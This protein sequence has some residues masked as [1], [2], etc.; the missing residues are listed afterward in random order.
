MNGRKQQIKKLRKKGLKLHEIGEKFQIT[1]ERVRQI[2]KDDLKYCDIHSK[3]YSD[4]CLYCKTEKEYKKRINSLIKDNLLEEIK[5][6]SFQDRRKE[7]VIE[8]K[9][10]IKKLKDRYGFNLHEIGRLLC[11]D[12]TSIANLY[13]Q[14]A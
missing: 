6:L 11:R 9:M 4:K 3:N 14:N 7:T 12:H 10:L 2:L 5:R 13:Y 8:R 1:S